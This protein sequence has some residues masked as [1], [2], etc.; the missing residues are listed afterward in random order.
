M[1]RFHEHKE[2]FNKPIFISDTDPY[3]IIYR[4]FQ[5]RHTYEVRT[6]LWNFVETVL[7]S[8]NIQYHDP[9]ERLSLIHF[10]DQPEGLIEATMKIAQ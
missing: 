5:D 2:F 10:Y 7:T 1:Q 8:D 3:E 9:C 4:Y 6:R